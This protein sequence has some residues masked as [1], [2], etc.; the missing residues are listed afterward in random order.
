MY[1]IDTFWAPF[2]HGSPHV[3]VNTFDGHEWNVKRRSDK[4]LLKTWT[5]GEGKRKYKYKV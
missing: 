1:Y 4:K 3:S 5:I 2:S